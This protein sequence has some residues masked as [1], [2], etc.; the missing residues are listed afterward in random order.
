ME[1]EG[2]VKDEIKVVYRAAYDRHD[3][4]IP[5]KR[6]PAGFDIDS[7]L[8]R[9]LFKEKQVNVQE[10]CLVVFNIHENETSFLAEHIKF[11]SD[12]LKNYFGGAKSMSRSIK[13]LLP[14]DTASFFSISFN[15]LY[16]K[17]RKI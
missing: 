12:R 16:E 8:Y 15:I 14:A 6:I 13:E 3:L 17:K 9:D 4:I 2:I 1:M 10:N 11:I 7:S 5:I